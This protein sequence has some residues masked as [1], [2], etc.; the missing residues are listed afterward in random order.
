MCK[1]I[2]S[3]VAAVL[4]VIIGGCKYMPAIDGGVDRNSVASRCVNNAV[5][6]ARRRSGIGDIVPDPL[7]LKRFQAERSVELS[8]CAVVGLAVVNTGY[9]ITHERVKPSA[10]PVAARKLFSEMVERA[11]FVVAQQRDKTINASAYA[12]HFANE[13]SARLAWALPTTASE[14]YGEAPDWKKFL[15]WV[16]NDQDVRDAGLVDEELTD[17]LGEIVV[18]VTRHP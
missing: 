5:I 17:A 6:E 10:A 1:P 3:F 16:G 12:A 11:A 7:K 9:A 15:V 14:L 2:W 4:F 13:E 8:M 18:V